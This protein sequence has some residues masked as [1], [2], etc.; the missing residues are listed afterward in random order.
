LLDEDKNSID[1]LDNVLSGDK[2]IVG[3]GRAIATSV[4]MDFK[5]EKYCLWNGKTMMG[6]SALGIEIPTK[7]LSNGEIYSKAMKELKRL[8]QLKP[9][10]N[11]LYIDLFLHTIAAE[12]EGIDVLNTITQGLDISIDPHMSVDELKNMEFVMEKYLEEF[13]ES[14][15]DKI[16]FGVKLELYQDE[17]NTGRQYSTTTGYIDLLAIDQETKEFVVIELK[18]GKTSDA[19]VGQILR[20]MSWVQENLADNKPVKGIIIAKEKDK[21]LEYALKLTNNIDLFLYNVNFNIEKIT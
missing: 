14:N 19:V 17:E 21:N 7:G 12:D 1:R 10:F 18:K 16:D 20:Y 11:F 2:H 6:F 3:F 8:I 13:I 5:P 9:G 4:L 15:F